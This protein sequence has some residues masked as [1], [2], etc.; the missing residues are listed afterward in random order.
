MVGLVEDGDVPIGSKSIEYD[1][2][3]ELLT[4]HDAVSRFI[5]VLSD[6]VHRQALN[7]P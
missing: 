3:F 2:T 4:Y 5:G 6:L 1:S 7:C